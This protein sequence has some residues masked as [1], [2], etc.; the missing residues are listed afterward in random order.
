[1]AI[2][3][4]RDPVATPSSGRL[5][6]ALRLSVE[7]ASTLGPEQARLVYRL[8]E[9]NDIVFQDGT[10]ETEKTATVRLAPSTVDHDVQLRRSDRGKSRGAIFVMGSV[11]SA[12]DDETPLKS[13][14]VELDGGGS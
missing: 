3:V 5:P 8:S 10:K 1:M 12:Q 4:L 13:V 14:R 2:Q 7:L 11:F 9:S 6:L